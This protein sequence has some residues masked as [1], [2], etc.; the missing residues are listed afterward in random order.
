MQCH[1]NQWLP[2]D[3]DKIQITSIASQQKSRAPTNVDNA[4]RSGSWS[5]KG[6]IEKR[7]FISRTL[8]NG[9]LDSMAP[10]QDGNRSGLTDKKSFLRFVGILKWMGAVTM[11]MQ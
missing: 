3:L 4:F 9:R 11:I 7:L 1:Q 2:S 10:S 8:L 6:I 5:R